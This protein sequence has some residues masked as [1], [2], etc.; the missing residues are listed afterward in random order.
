MVNHVN[1]VGQSQLGLLHY[2]LRQ[3]PSNTAEKGSTENHKESNKYKISTLVSE[4]GQTRADHE[5]NDDQAPVALLQSEQEGEH[6]DEDNAGGLS[7]GVQGYINVFKTP[8]RQ[9]YVQ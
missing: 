7:D 1:W 9:S 8:L 6:E 3:G 4:H 5:D 2:Q